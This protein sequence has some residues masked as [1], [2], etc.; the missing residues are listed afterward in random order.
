VL[1]VAV[2]GLATAV[3]VLLAT[4]QHDDG[5][6]AAATPPAAPPPA[7]PTPSPTVSHG[8]PAGRGHQ[9]SQPSAGQGTNPATSP[10]PT[11][12]PPTPLPRHRLLWGAWIGGHLTGLDAPWDMRAVKKFQRMTGKGPSVIHFSSPFAACHGGECA[13]YPFP[14]EAFDKVRRYGAIPFFS[15][16]SSSSPIQPYEPGFTLAS[17]VDGR[18][19]AYIKAWAQ[20]ARSWGHPF[21]LQFDWEM[22]GSWY[23]W[24]EG[25]NGNRHGEFVQA[26]RHVHD[27]FTS[28]GATK[29]TWVWCPNID[30][31]GSFTPLYPLYPGNQYVDW[32]CLDGYNRN[33]PWESFDELYGLSYRLLEKIAP[34]KPI[35]IGEIASTEVGGSKAA[36]ITDLL[37]T[38]LPYHYPLIRG[39]LWFEK[40]AG[41]A[42]PIETSRASRLAFARA[43]AS[44][45]YIPNAFASLGG[46]K[47]RP[48]GT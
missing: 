42:Y 22:N 37:S 18:H 17:I 32:T 34:T 1:I 39:V 13:S 28:V 40:Y 43:I 5:S 15:W 47:V 48:P 14:T 20:A 29:A 26:W 24:A 9:P 7:N 16:G 4:R 44:P 33:V 46:R 23:P 38:E 25:A 45:V 11:K 8:K 6:H 19:D 41:N 31:T 12:G 27:I 35:I 36:W 3:V 21:F 30:P 10:P 2:A